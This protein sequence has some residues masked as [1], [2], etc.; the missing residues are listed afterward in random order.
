M[1]NLTEN[2]CVASAIYILYYCKLFL[3]VTLCEID[4]SLITDKPSPQDIKHTLEL[5]SRTIWEQILARSPQRSTGIRVASVIEFSLCLFSVCLFSSNFLIL[6]QHNIRPP[7]CDC[8]PCTIEFVAGVNLKTHDTSTRTVMNVLRNLRPEWS[9]R[10][11]ISPGN[12]LWFFLKLSSLSRLHTQN[13]PQRLSQPRLTFS[14][15]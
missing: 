14:K 5:C 3:Y 2:I 10:G 11:M 1:W 12:R 7:S 13:P 6:L 15:K 8:S 4:T 9:W